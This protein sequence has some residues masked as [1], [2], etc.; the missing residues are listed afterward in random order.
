VGAAVIVR[1]A[2]NDRDV[3]FGFGVVVEPDWASVRTYHPGPNAAVSA[4]AVFTIA[5]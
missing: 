4:L 1:I 3:G 2:G 5:V